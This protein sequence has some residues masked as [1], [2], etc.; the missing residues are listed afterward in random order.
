M[1]AIGSII[2]LVIFLSLA[3]WLGLSNQRESDANALKCYRDSL[4][5]FRNINHRIMKMTDSLSKKSVPGLHPVYP[6]N[7]KIKL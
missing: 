5:Q 2:L 7:K 3:Y 4:N 1:R 6:L